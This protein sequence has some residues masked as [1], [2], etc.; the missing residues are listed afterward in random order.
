M[1]MGMVKVFQDFARGNDLPF[2]DEDEKELDVKEAMAYFATAPLDIT[3]GNI[4]VVRNAYYF[5]KTKEWNKASTDLGTQ[6]LTQIV[7]AGYTTVDWTSALI[8]DHKFKKISKGQAK[9]IGMA[10]GYITGG[11][12]VTL[13]TNLI[14][15]I[16]SKAKNDSYVP[17][18]S[19]E[20]KN[21]I[22]ELEEMKDAGE[23][24][25]PQD[26]WDKVLEMEKEINPD[27]ELEPPPADS[28]S[29]IKDAVSG[30]KWYAKSETS[31]KAGLY[32]FDKATW[33]FI[34]KQAPELALTPG[35]R[36]SSSPSQQEEAMDWYL[37][38]NNEALA[39]EGVKGTL[40]NLYAAHILGAVLS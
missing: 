20:L 1:V 11:V 17:P 35:G 38:Y 8:M 9:D 26:V 3:V 37:K 27:T 40:P 23:V 13:V 6:A 36:V 39:R 31:D 32:M 5:A 2:W 28:A 16:N 21:N 25:I 30:G 10:L 29:I 22:N 12:P 15:A 14:N 24:E 34:D 19:I 7:N 33:D 18:L 4:P